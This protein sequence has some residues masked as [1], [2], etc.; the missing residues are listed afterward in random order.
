MTLKTT[1]TSPD[2]SPELV[3]KT[4]VLEEQLVS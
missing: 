4:S 3:V 2:D 1:Q